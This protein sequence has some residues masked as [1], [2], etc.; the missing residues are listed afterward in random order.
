MSL[1]PD[2]PFPGNP[3]LNQKRE[4]WLRL[5]STSPKS[6]YLK[7]QLKVGSKTLKH[8]WFGVKSSL[9]QISKESM[10]VVPMV[11]IHLLYAS[12]VAKLKLKE[13]DGRAPLGVEPAALFDSTRENSPGPNTVRIDR[14]IVLS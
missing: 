2:E 6:S 12:M 8:P 14:L 1:S 11:S 4:L 5:F 3:F 13:I 7:Q 9:Y 10:K